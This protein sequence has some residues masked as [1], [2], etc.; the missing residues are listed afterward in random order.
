LLDPVQLRRFTNLCHGAAETRPGPDLYYYEVI[1]CAIFAFV[2]LL[3]FELLRPHLDPADSWLYRLV[4]SVSVNVRS[5]AFGG[6]AEA[7]AMVGMLLASAR[8]KNVQSTCSWV[9]KCSEIH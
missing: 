7:T 1:E 4:S 6:R 3:G 9:F 5:L 2:S 8:N